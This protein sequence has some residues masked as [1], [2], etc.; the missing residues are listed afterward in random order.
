M[1]GFRC[2]VRQPRGINT[3]QMTAVNYSGKK[4]IQIFQMTYPQSF[5]SF[6]NAQLFCFITVRVKCQ[7]ILSNS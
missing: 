6:E 1:L 7:I 2:S 5:N 4:T 3:M